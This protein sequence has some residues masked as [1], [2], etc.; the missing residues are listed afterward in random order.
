M[1]EK[2]LNYISIFFKGIAMGCADV[3]P[4]V[5]G[6]T[7]ALI[8]GIYDRLIFAIKS[9]NIEAFQLL[10]RGEIK[11]LWKHLDGNFLISL[12]LGIAFSLITLANVITFFIVEYPIQLWSFFFGLIIIS[13]MLVLRELQKRNLANMALVI[14]GA[15]IAL[16][17]TSATP[18]E[19]PQNYFFL[20][21]TGSI[22]IC[23]MILPGISGA[24]ILLILG[25]YYFVLEAL[26][27]FDILAIIVFA[28]GCV[29]GLLL[30]ARIISWF[31]EN[32][33]DG[34][35]A[36]LAGFMI[37]ALN[38]IWPWKKVIEN[39]LNSKG[40]LVPFIKQN[41]WPAEYVEQVG[42]DPF[43]LEALLFMALGIVLIMG[44]DRIAKMIRERNH[45]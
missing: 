1:R 3:V 13:A 33:K 38:E 26:K 24:F 20:F 34:T 44:I 12:I 6:G 23:A 39:R 4:G 37:G 14:T 18:A 8:T 17:I 15:L 32:Y 45:I 9:V 16:L 5:S 31:L 2:Y 40:E 28:S 19:M 35:I 25:Q 42:N 29:F 43:L 7:I 11:L 10:K 27:S 36:I 22:A 30:F 41:V 21:L